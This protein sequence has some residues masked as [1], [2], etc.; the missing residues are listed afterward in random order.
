MAVVVEVGVVVV[1]AV[2]VVVVVVVAMVGRNT[3]SWVVVSAL[4]IFFFKKIIL[5][6]FKGFVNPPPL[7]YFFRKI[8]NNP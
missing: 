5:F 1:D 3:S 2:D 4:E 8:G 6:C 7:K